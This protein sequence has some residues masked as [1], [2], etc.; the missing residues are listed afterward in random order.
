MDHARCNPS[1][2][3]VTKV[4][5]QG[6]GQVLVFPLC[7]IYKYQILLMRITQKV[8]IISMSYFQDRRPRWLYIY[9]CILVTKGQRSRSPA[10]IEIFQGHVISRKVFLDR[11]FDDV[12]SG[13]E[14]RSE[15]YSKMTLTL[16][17]RN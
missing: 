14:A 5:G 10:D 15:P 1:V 11:S 13:L 16:Y 8:F 4:I 2:I 3:F 9:V 12:T 7:S 6:Q 17:L